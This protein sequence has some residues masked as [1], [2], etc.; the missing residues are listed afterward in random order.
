M[1]W[2]LFALVVFGGA[3]AL[4]QDGVHVRF[5]H[6]DGPLG[7]RELRALFPRARLA[8]C[9]STFLGGDLRLEIRVES[10]GAVVIDRARAN[11]EVA[12]Y[13]ACVRRLVAS[14]HAGPQVA[15]TR[16]H[17]TISFPSLGLAPSPER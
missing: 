17:V 12:P 14:E 16:A 2:S 8:E 10:D 13:V 11:E 15:P 4:A 5:D 3:M 7:R 9:Q 6:V 1:R